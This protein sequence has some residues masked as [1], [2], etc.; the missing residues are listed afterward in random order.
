M[1]KIALE[2]FVRTNPENKKQGQVLWESDFIGDPYFQQY[3]RA[4]GRNA[5][6]LMM[7]M[8]RRLHVVTHSSVR[9]AQ[10]S[11]GPS[12]YS[13]AVV[14]AV[15]VFIHQCGGFDRKVGEC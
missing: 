7:N 6:D 10:L 2:N 3:L 9:A 14:R 4:D 1:C 12:P 5:L 11:T 13:A 15:H 8:V